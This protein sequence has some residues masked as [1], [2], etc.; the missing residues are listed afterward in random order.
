VPSVAVNADEVSGQIADLLEEGERVRAAWICIARPTP[1]RAA[2]NLGVSTV[3]STVASAAIGAVVPGVGL[4]VIR[5]PAPL[6]ACVTDKRLI[7]VKKREAGNQ[8]K[9]PERMLL[10]GDLAQIRATLRGGII[11]NVDLVSPQGDEV[12]ATLGFGV[13]GK[14]A[15]E[16]ADAVTSA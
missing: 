14:A 4:T 2:K 10:V 9:G 3:A 12:F 7:A 5:Q 16:F 1:G 13:R 11:N 6:L 8:R 15:R